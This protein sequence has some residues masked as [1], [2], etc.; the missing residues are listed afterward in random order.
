MFV[1]FR[2]IPTAFRALFRM[3]FIGLLFAIIAG[4]IALGVA[5]ANT[6]HWPPSALTIVIAAVIAVLAGY[7]AGLTTLVSEI[8][9]GVKDVE[10]D[11]VHGIE[12]D[13]SHREP[14]HS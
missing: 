14:A 9:H 13:V 2:L 7:A 6:P 3:V 12:G 8:M 10:Q 4:G 11:V 5:Y 1:L